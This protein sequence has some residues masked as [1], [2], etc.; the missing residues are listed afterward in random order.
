MI[1]QTHFCLFIYKGNEITMLRYLHTHVQCSISHHN[2][3]LNCPS[4]DEWEKTVWYIIQ[5]FKK[6][7]FSHLWQHEWTWEVL[8]YKPDGGRQILCSIIYMW[9]INPKNT[10]CRNQIGWWF[11][12]AGEGGTGRYRSNGTHLQL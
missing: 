7:K 4:V 5:S 8:H 9:N 1:Q 11:P 2:Q 12:R 10:F 6:R 3:G